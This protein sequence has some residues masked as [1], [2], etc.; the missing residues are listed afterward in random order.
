MLRENKPQKEYVYEEVS[1]Y[2]LDSIIKNLNI[3]MVNLL[4]IDIEGAEF[5]IFNHIDL[6]VLNRIKMVVGEIHLQHGDISS[7]VDKLRSVGFRVK[8]VHPPLWRRGFS[9]RIKLYGMVKLKILRNIPGY[10][11]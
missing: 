8:L 10:K 1:V 11:G 5:E 6:E 7:I 3:N 9:Y 2:T 4:K